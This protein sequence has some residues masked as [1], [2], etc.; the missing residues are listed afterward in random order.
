MKKDSPKN[1]S[2]LG[3]GE[4]AIM[5]HIEEYHDIFNKIVVYSNDSDLTY[6]IEGMKDISII[7][8]IA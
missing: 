4:A 5:L 6:L 3:E 2:R 8:N 1:N 7:K